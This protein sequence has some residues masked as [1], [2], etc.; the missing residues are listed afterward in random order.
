[1]RLLVYRH[2]ACLKHDPG[3]WHPERAERIPAAADG[4]RAS[5]ADLDEREAPQASI[6]DLET[7]HLP[8]Y[9]RGIR[10][11]C[12]AGGGPLDPDTIVSADSWE[13]SLR[14]AGSGIAAVEAL[15]SGEGGAAFLAVRPPGHHAEPDRAMGFCVFNNIGIAAEH[16]ARSGQRVAIV[17]WDVHHGNAT[18]VFFYGRP[19]VLY[20]SMHEYPFYP[21]SG[22]L[23]E[24]G[25]G[26]GEGFTLNLPFPAG[27]AGDVY[28]SAWQRVVL[29]VLRQFGPDWILVSAGYDAHVDDQLAD[30]RLREADY[31]RM[32]YR[33][34]EIVGQGRIV[35]FLE[36]GYDLDAITNSV[37]ATVRGVM[38]EFPDLSGDES[39]RRAHHIL[40]LAS[41]HHAKSW[42]L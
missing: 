31:G 18:Q 25:R 32:A 33:I 28:E 30:L 12:N 10:D 38:G 19:D 20:L 26:S 22:W 1:M 27:T 41:D 42:D 40:E 23:D 37:A 14:A 3:R 39:P 29:P 8:S 13:A 34:T 7:V 5:G 11:Y 16:L 4:T 21:G 6:E 24:T 36:G 2:D 9:V 15:R 35:F 17:D